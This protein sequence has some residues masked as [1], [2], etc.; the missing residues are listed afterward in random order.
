MSGTAVALLIAALAAVFWPGIAMYDTVSQYDQVLS[1]E[2]TDWHPPIMVRLW[3][4]LHPLWPGTAPMF[5]LQLALYTAGVALIVAALVQVARWRSAIALTALAFSPLLIG[6]QMVVLKDGQMLGALLAAFGIVA[7]FRLTGRS[8]PLLAA[9]V[10]ALLIT[11]AT[12]VRANA[13]FATAPLVVLLLPRPRSIIARGAIALSATAALLL[14]T[15]FID[16]RIFGAEPSGVAN[17]QPLFDLAAIAVATPRSPSPFSPAERSEIARRHCV[18]SYFWD[19]LGEPS[20][21]EPVT[22]RLDEEPERTLYE[23]LARAVTEHPLA[24]AEH[25]LKHWNSTE[26]WLVQPN[27]QEAAPPDEAEQNDLGLRTPAS[28]LMPAW[29]S[30]AAAEAGTPLGWPMLWTVVALLVVPAAWRRRREPA[31]S[32]ALALVASVLTLEASFLVISI[33]SDIRYHLWSM[34]ASALALILL[35]DVRPRARSWIAGAAVLAMVV[36]G[37]LIE[38]WI[39]PPAPDSY[40]AMIAAPSG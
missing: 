21:C 24:Y 34:M 20:A 32:L 5:A 8:V 7:Y 15:P 28:P 36:A 16:Q 19:P 1:N 10:A 25:R 14:A 29:Q 4:L 17:S 12:L 33:A 30:V 27:L 2:V 31:G 23:D 11:Y 40:E 37:G 13:I 26:R 3:Q 35:C 38:R 6:W 39:L 18:K 9:S 22:E